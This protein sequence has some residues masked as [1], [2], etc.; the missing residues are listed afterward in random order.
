M[1]VDELKALGDLSGVLPVQITWW[2]L[3][4]RDPRRKPIKLLI[5]LQNQYNFNFDSNGTLNSKRSSNR[6]DDYFIPF[7]YDH[8]I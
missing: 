2:H 7:F 3:G 6:L 8:R 5:E 1:A 4:M